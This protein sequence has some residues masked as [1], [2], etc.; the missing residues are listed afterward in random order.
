M[1]EAD[2]ARA[3]ENTR[4]DLGVE[5]TGLEHLPR[6][7][8]KVRDVYELGGGRLLMVASDRVS[9]FDVILPTPIPDKGRVLTALTVHWLQWLGLPHHLISDDIQDAGL[10]LDASQLAAL[11]GRSLIVQQAQVIPFEC[12]VRGYLSGSGW[13]DYRETGHVCGIHL[14]E[15]L[16]E[17]QQLDPIFTPATK[18]ESGHDQNVPFAR[19]ADPLGADLAEQLR[20][21]S[22]QVYRR[23]A[24]YAR[25]RG[26]ILADTKLEWGRDPETGEILLV[27]EVLTP[28]SSRYWPAEAYRPGGPIPSFDKQFVR[29]WLRGTGWREESGTPPPEL[30]SEVVDETRAKYIQAYEMLTDQKL[31]W[32]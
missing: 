25:E 24:T 16:V 15:G 19:M 5:A 4:A 9:A 17:S 27:D 18:A 13:R 21:L 8:G 31:P 2:P 6:R 7:S 23:G 26:L 14:P 10:G 32:Q 11:E 22:L 12:V 3:G 20:D 28:D 1:A 30:P 29:D